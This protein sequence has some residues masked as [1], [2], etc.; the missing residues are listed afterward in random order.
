MTKSIAI[1]V[2][3]CLAILVAA[4]GNAF[5]QAG[6]TGGTLGKTDKSASGG[7]EQGKQTG[8][9]RRTG[10]E[11]SKVSSCHGIVGTWAFHTVTGIETVFRQDGSGS[12]T[13]GATGT[14]SCTGATA[15]AKWSNGA[16]DTISISV[17]GNSLAIHNNWGDRFTADRK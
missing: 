7:E 16:V 14:W 10:T 1:A 17:D 11:R 13:N 9:R 4:D 5:A 15:T 12:Q 2:V 8:E 3:S 6:S